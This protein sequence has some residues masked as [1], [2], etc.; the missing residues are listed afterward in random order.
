[1]KSRKRVCR[2]EELEESPA[3]EIYELKYT[4]IE[5]RDDVQMAVRVQGHNCCRFESCAVSEYREGK[6]EE[7]TLLDDGFSRSLLRE[8]SEIASNIASSF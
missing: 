6:A 5:G 2:G 4:N 3:V 7:D 1:M 8:C